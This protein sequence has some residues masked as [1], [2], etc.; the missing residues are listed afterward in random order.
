MVYVIFGVAFIG[1]IIYVLHQNIEYG[2]CWGFVG[3]AL[4]IVGL[5][6]KA[7]IIGFPGLFLLFGSYYFVWKKKNTGAGGTY[8]TTKQYNSLVCWDYPSNLNNM[9]TNAHEQVVTLVQLIEGVYSIAPYLRK[10]CGKGYLSIYRNHTGDHTLSFWYDWDDS[11]IRETVQQNIS[12]LD[13]GFSF[14]NDDCIEYKTNRVTE[15]T[16][17]C[18][19]STRNCY[20]AESCIYSLK[21]AFPNL[22][23]QYRTE[24][25]TQLTISFTC[26]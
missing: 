13:S 12:R 14:R 1:A 4:F 22:K 18:W 24:D 6:T 9:P 7:D 26:F 19:D 16:E 21:Y 2:V 10:D 5:I 11:T 8:S 3:L 20:S 23:I 25:K 15:V 17:F